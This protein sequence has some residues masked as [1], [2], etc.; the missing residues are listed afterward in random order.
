MA[1]RKH[2]SKQGIS[3]LIAT[4]LIIAFTVA[5]AVIVINWGTS[6]TRDLQ[7]NTG[8][9]ADFEITCAQDVV[10]SV[11]NACVKS[12]GSLRITVANDGSKALDQVIVRTTSVNGAASQQYTTAVTTPPVV[13]AFAQVDVSVPS[14]SYPTQ[15]AKVE[16]IPY[17]T[18]GNGDSEPCSSNKRSYG[19]ETTQLAACS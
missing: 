8:S 9:S 6:F 17:V 14:G 10:F 12:D 7:D 18:V 11:K 13:G 5:L 16:V 1:Q 4:V 19:V 2:I 15:P 3:P